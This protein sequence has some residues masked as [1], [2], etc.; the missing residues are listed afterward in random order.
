MHFM[1]IHYFFWGWDGFSGEALLGIESINFIVK[2]RTIELIIC[3]KKW[4]PIG[5]TV[6][7]LKSIVLKYKEIEN[8]IGI[9]IKDF[10]YILFFLKIEKNIIKKYKCKSIGK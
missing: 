4:V 6:Q 9:K 1:E 5:N 7:Y 8:N 3:H 2:N 10:R